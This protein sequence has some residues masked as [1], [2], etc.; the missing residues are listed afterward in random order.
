MSARGLVGAGMIALASCDSC[1]PPDFRAVPKVGFERMAAAHLQS[2]ISASN[3]VEPLVLACF[4]ASRQR[5]LD[6]GWP[7]ECGFGE[8][9][10]SC[11]VDVARL[12]R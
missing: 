1:L 10:G 4:E 6:A 11:G 3:C 5:C 2:C 9:E 8:V 7:K 12:R